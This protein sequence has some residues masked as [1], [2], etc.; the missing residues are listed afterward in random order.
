[1]SKWQSA[2]LISNPSL[3]SPELPSP[4]PH[5]G[6]R[7]CS[8]FVLSHPVH[9]VFFHFFHARKRRKRDVLNRAKG[10]DK[11]GISI[12][13]CFHCGNPVLGQRSSYSFFLSISTLRNKKKDLFI[14]FIIYPP[15]YAYYFVLLFSFLCLGQRISK[16]NREMGLATLFCSRFAH[17]REE[18]DGIGRDGMGCASNMCPNMFEL[19]NT[20][21]GRMSW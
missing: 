17:K 21:R 1:M 16:M 14:P 2:P 5:L 19:A 13:S 7:T 9:D 3:S 15:A 10:K 6:L 8:V 20:H 4:V 11:R 18:L 12:I